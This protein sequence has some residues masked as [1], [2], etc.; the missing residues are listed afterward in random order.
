MATTSAFYARLE[1]ALERKLGDKP[2]QQQI[3]DRV[4]LR[5]TAVSAWKQGPSL[6]PLHTV[7]QLAKWSGV[8]VEWLL[9]GRGPMFPEAAGDDPFL[10]AA[11]DLLRQLPKG[12]RARTLEMLKIKL[13]TIG[14][15]WPD[16]E[17][18]AIERVKRETGRF[19]KPS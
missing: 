17:I 15:G 9:T 5:Q 11:N 10:Q 18:E 12:E 6:P 3:A 1:Q 2:K 13:D 16:T 4:G 7:A 14:S 19:R 8:C